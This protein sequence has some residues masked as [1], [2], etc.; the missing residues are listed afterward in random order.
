MKVLFAASEAYPLIKTGG[1]GDVIHGLPVA[2]KK[3]GVDVCLVLPAYRG[4]LSKLKKTQIVGRFEIPG[5]NRIHKVTIIESCFD[6]EIPLLLVDVAELFDRDGGPYL[7]PD[8]DDWPDNAE[9]FAVFSRA[10]AKLSMDVLNRGWKPDVIHCHDWQTGLVPAFLSKESSAPKT[11]FTIH[12][13]AYAGLFNYQTFSDL[14]LPQ[15]WWSPELVEF[16]DNMS[17]LKAGILFADR[18]TTVSPRYAYEITT[19]DFGYRMDGVLRSIQHKLTGIL[20][21]IDH[22]TWDPQTDPHIEANY[23]PN[24]HHLKAK[25]ENKRALLETL[26]VKATRENLQKPL[27]GFIGRLVEQKGV[28]LLLKAIPVLFEREDI[29]MVILGTG[30]EQLERQLAKMAKRYPDCLTVELSYSESLAHL[31]EASADIFLMP[32]RFEPCGLNQLYSLRYGTPP[33]VHFVGGLVDSVVDANSENVA[34]GRANG[35]Q[36]M[37]PTQESFVGAVERAIGLYQ[38]KKIWNRIVTTAMRADFSWEHSCEEYISL[39]TGLTE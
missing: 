22:D 32:S 35:F 28:D 20:N 31:I 18:V 38:N 5:A 39:Y 24:N 14:G 13:L 1:L 6:A 23:S 3:K 29:S 17:M 33:V 26:G 30:D 7:H 12:N 27:L 2:L 10:V 36:F 15:S 4:V 21:G 8:G 25:R 34:S 11:V 9:R 16:Y 37:Q 19:A